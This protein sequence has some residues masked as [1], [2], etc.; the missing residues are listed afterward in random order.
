MIRRSPRKR[1]MRRRWPMPESIWSATFEFGQD[2]CRAATT[3]GY[4]E[5]AGCSTRS[6]GE[7]RP[8]QYRQSA[9]LS[10]LDQ[11]RRADL[12]AHRHP[13]GRCRQYRARLERDADRCDH[14]VAPDLDHLHVAAAATRAGQ[15]GARKAG[16][17]EVDAFGPD[18]KQHR[19]SGTLQVVDNQ[20]DQATGTLKLKAEFANTDLQLWPGQF[21]NVRIAGRYAA[22]RWSWCRRPRFSAD[23]MD[24]SCS[25][26][27]T[28][29]RL[30]CAR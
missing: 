19:R 23:R 28:T 11:D 24:R 10:G 9:R 22:T 25:S 14:A 1:R 29:T 4:P 13:P 6:A 12:G 27:A 15:Q 18:H 16:A 26:S 3:G 5:G 7:S 2:Q 21:V 17:V 20:I 8:G 30:P